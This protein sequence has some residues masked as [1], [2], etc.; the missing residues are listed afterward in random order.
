MQV[1]E[2]RVRPVVKY[3]VTRWHQNG[4]SAGCESC[5]EFSNETQAETARQALVSHD[6]DYQ[7]D[8]RG[9]GNPYVIVHY[10]FSEDAPPVLYASTFKE[11]NDLLE[12]QRQKGHSFRLYKRA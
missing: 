11:A 3:Q 1:I 5:G 10:G 4:N 9:E 8:I 12:E 7:E 2:Y 6:R